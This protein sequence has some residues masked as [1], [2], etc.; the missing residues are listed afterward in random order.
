MLLKRLPEGCQT[1]ILTAQISSIVRCPPS[2]TTV[3][4]ELHYF[5][6][7]TPKSTWFSLQVL[8][9]RLLWKTEGCDKKNSKSENPPKTI[10]KTHLLHAPP[11]LT[12]ERS[13]HKSDNTLFL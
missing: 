9:Y 6:I 10:K 7:S 11:R 8:N 4:V 2:S 5:A 12:Q 13:P 1:P 3:Y